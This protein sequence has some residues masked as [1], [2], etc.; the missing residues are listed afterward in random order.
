M[1]DC[2]IVDEAAK[3]T[4][5]ELLVPLVR[6]KKVV[7]VGDHLQLPPILDRKVIK[8]DTQLDV[9]ELERA[10]FGKIWSILPDDCKQTLDIQ[11][12]MHPCIGTLI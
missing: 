2:V 10:G 12:R 1:F 6:T 8:E 3:A 5:P 9:D 11:Y 4:F 7:L